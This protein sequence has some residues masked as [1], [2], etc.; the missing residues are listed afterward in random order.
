[1]NEPAT[2]DPITYEVI[3][4]DEGKRVGYR[5]F[6]ADRKRFE[7]GSRY[8]GT[9]AMAI[10]P[11]EPDEYPARALD[12]IMGELEAWGIGEERLYR[13]LAELYDRNPLIADRISAA[14][15]SGCQSG[16]LHDPSAYLASRLRPRK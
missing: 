2:L 5:P 9:G 6:P 16:S 15:V 4:N 14:A 12:E 13:Q 10:T 7:Q 11:T 3:Y 1:M 8:P